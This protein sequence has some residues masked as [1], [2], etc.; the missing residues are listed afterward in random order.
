[1]TM[2]EM[3][4]REGDDVC[5]MPISDVSLGNL[6]G[7]VNHWGSCNLCIVRVEITVE[8]MRETVDHYDA[9]VIEDGTVR[10]AANGAKPC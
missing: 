1:M 2:R 5:V 10:G 8:P 3:T 7:Q 9:L 6:T 4:V